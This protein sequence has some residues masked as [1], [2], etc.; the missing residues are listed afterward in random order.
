MQFTI[1]EKLGPTAIAEL[2][3]EWQELFSASDAA[4]FLSWEWISTWHRWLGPQLA[5]RILCVRAEQRLIGLLALGEEETGLA[6]FKLKRLSLLG[7]RHGGADYLGVLARAGYEHEASTAISNHLTSNLKADV[8]SLE[9]LAADAVTRVA[10]EQAFGQSAQ[11]KYQQLPRYVCPQI[12]LDTDWPTLLKRSRRADNFKRRW[13]QLNALPG[14][15]YRSVTAPTETDAAFARFLQ[16]H[17]ARWKEAGGSEATGHTALVQFHQEVTQKLSQA[18]WLRFD[19]LWCEGEC[20]A[21]IYGVET[22]KQFYYFNAGYDP[23]WSRYSVGLVLLGL[24]ISNAIQRGV[25]VYD[26]LRGTESYKSDWATTTRET[27]VIQIA[28]QQWP[29]TLAMGF[30]TL[31]QELKTFAQAHLPS[32]LQQSLRSLKRQYLLSR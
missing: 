6:G 17:E 21:T 29:T 20:R 18:G 22:G 23:A 32:G 13:R 1:E 15:E 26:F 30:S 3:T 25:Q 10:F 16:L 7:A 2:Q 11:S 5:P 8:L 24:S 4:P 28:N 27:V 14:F 9:E 19:E 31:Q 12:H